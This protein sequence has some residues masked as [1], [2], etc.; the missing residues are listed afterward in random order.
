[1]WLGNYV[2]FLRSRSVCGRYDADLR[3]DLANDG[4][5]L[6]QRRGET[7]NTTKGVPLRVIENEAVDLVPT[8]GA[9]GLAD[10]IC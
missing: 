9:P 10:L 2:E 3:I 7:F 5:W 4:Q 8:L 1:M 6:P